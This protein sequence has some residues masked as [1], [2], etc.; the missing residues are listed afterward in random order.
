MSKPTDN[1]TAEALGLTVNFGA[2][3]EELI[4]NL[5]DAQLSNVELTKEK[6]ALVEENSRLRTQV[7]KKR[8]QGGETDH[9]GY[10]PHVVGFA[11]AVL[12]TVEF[13]VPLAGFGPK[14]ATEVADSFASDDNYL[15]NL[16]L[17]LY[18]FNSLNN[19]V[20]E[21]LECFILLTKAPITCGVVGV[22]DPLNFEAHLTWTECRRHRTNWTTDSDS[23]GSIDRIIADAMLVLEWRRT[24]RRGSRASSRMDLAEYTP[25]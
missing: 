19:N 2:T 12:F 6:Q 17:K 25:W 20:S 22:R 21:I 15:S 11:K 3:R 16:T 18:A 5:K 1:I 10:K 4:A 8:R 23:A 13:F 7:T 14:P 24:S 9:L